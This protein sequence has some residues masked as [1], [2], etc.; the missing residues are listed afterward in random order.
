MS[1][2][3]LTDEQKEAVEAAGK[4]VI[5]SAAAGSGK[6]AV[7]AERCAYLVCDAPPE[8]RCRVDEL[9]VLTFTDAAAAEMRARIIDTLRARLHARPGDAHLQEQVQLAG[10][11]QISTIHS[12]CFWLIRRWFSEL[13]IDPTAT[14]LD[15]DEAALLKREVLDALFSRLYAAA[16]G[17]SSRPLGSP[18]DENKG[19][20]TSGADAGPPRTGQPPR[21]ADP[22]LAQGFV[23]L[24]D[25]YGLG[26][27]RDIAALV[28][29]LFEFLTSLPDPEGW[30]EAARDL[31]GKH[32]AQ[33]VLAAIARL[34]TELDRQTEHCREVAGQ[35]EAGDSAGHF[36]AAQIRH[37][38]DQLA[39]WAARLPSLRELVPRDADTKSALAAYDAVREQIA[40]FGFSRK[41][42]PRLGK[43]TEPRVAAAWDAA[44]NH[45]RDV[46]DRLFGK[47]LKSRFALFSVDEWV[48]GLASTTPY[49][50]TII[51]LTFAFREAY[52]AQKRRTDALDFSDLERFAF[53]VL[54]DGDDQDRPSEVA[55][56]LHRRFAHV[57]VDEFQDINPIQQAIIRLASRETDPDRKDNLFV[58]GD[59]KQSIYRF[60]LAEPAIFSGRLRS[61]R[62][63]KRAGKA[64]SLRSNFRSRDEILEAA[65]LLF[66]QLMRAGVGDVVYDEEAELR[67]GR[68]AGRNEVHQPVEVHVLERAWTPAGGDEEEEE[69]AVERGVANLA[70]PAR[71]SP[72]EREAFLIGSQIRAWIAG[73]NDAPLIEGKPIRY[74][75]VAVLLR[76]AKVNAERMAAILASMGVPAY[77][78]AGGS[79][80]KALE[81]RDVLAVLQVLDNARQDIPLAA[82]LRNGV[83][84]DP[85][86]EDDLVR[87][88]CLD[89]DTP[90]HEAVRGYV[91]H[92]G[93]HDLRERLAVVLRCIERFRREVRRRPLAEV[94][95]SLYECRG[96]LAYASGLPNG[97]QRRANLLKLHELARKFGTFRRQGLHRFLRFI[98]TLEEQEQ[99][100]AAAPAIGES[101]DVVRIMTIHQAK[102]LEF[103]VVFV[104]GLGT[105][106]NLGDRSGSMIFERKARLALRVVDTERMIEYPSVAHQQAAD[107]IE[108]SAREEEL[109]ILYVA[110]TRAREKLV[111]VGSRS[112]VATWHAA[113]CR[114][115]GMSSP[116]RLRIA[117]ALTPLDW[118]LPALAGV[119]AGSVQGFADQS[120]DRP[121]FTLHL[122][123]REQMAGWSVEG[124]ADPCR[125]ETLYAASRGKALPAHEPHAA[126]DP[127]VERVLS[128][129][130]Y[131]YP[132]LAISSVRASV[133]A[134]EVKTFSDAV[135]GP[136]RRE[137]TAR[138]EDLGRRPGAKGGPAGLPGTAAQR[139]IITHRVLQHLDFDVATDP[140]GV[141]SELQRMT[142]AGLIEP[143]DR[144]AVD[145]ASL[146]WLATTPLAAAI[147][148]AGRAYRR[149]FT[150][151]A[152]E[153]AS[154]FDPTL[155][156]ARGDKVLVRGVVDGILPTA[157]G[158][159]V[160]DFKTDVIEP[161]EVPER[162]ERY[163][164]QMA[165]YARAM[166]RIWRRPVGTC[167]LVF[168]AAREVVSLEGAG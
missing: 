39:A 12:F 76:A 60:R 69:E 121:T 3:T 82:A 112:D 41:T 155:S 115:A 133:G 19:A 73:E 159:E 40:A 42:G 80:F 114:A 140:D 165:L 10:V 34:V 144:A 142:V 95:W 161:G 90:F 23:K 16:A 118:L 147:R 32:P 153:P 43:G 24:V 4:S 96:Y 44:R 31:P 58:V 168:L 146:E 103:P 105:K 72:V 148:K 145:A 77:A 25:D 111:L 5:V 7:V 46:K 141:A 26:D 70:D 48:D 86:S 64:I 160:I 27:D 120:A 130:E 81:V 139:G 135:L 15:A 1:K 150:Y 108:L 71:W 152:T 54:H 113:A 17:D 13:G 92:G 100:I 36:Y 35:I 93:E 55:R 45:L 134:S 109:R 52:D 151:I 37:Y 99:R 67:P 74:R 83:L 91:E 68:G 124:P 18:L 75:D 166:A 126:D 29:K 102:G 158:I 14:L 128:R 119:P 94:L 117:T 65:N 162:V 78:D 30:A 21:A 85:L 101:D 20:G 104:A 57:L 11:A 62:S 84:G 123:N 163:R 137:P 61:F 28:L 156:P 38:A 56:T 107:E 66:R 154:Y 125:A 50:G 122:H 59:V 136:D 79:L 87:I 116:T 33:A 98:E 47:R 51:D 131:T 129:L 106:F 138:S 149:E 6:T 2:F 89:R 9:L 49:V 167:R 22:A 63:D 127:Q 8:H 132:D 157:G 53:G 88:R 97:P 164:P 110:M 143:L